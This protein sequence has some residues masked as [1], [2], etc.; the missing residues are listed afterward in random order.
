[1]QQAAQMQQHAVATENVPE[2]LPEN[3]QG[4]PGFTIVSDMPKGMHMTY[5]SSTTDASGCTRTVSY[6][7]DGSD[8][9]P[10]M[11]RAASDSCDAVKPNGMAI[12]AKAEKPA[13]QSAVPGQ[14]V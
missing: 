4:A 11:T 6:S 13:E 12:P 2:N 14:K 8:A 3:L 1:M 9:A 7:S 5:Y 10:K